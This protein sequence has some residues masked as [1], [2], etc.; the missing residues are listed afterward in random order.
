MKYFKIGVCA[1]AANY[2]L[3]NLHDIYVCRQF[4]YQANCCL[5]FR[6]QQVLQ[7]LD[8]DTVDPNSNY[9]ILEKSLK[10]SHDECF[11]M[12][13]VKFNPKRHKKTPWI[14]DDIIKSINVRNKLYKKLK[15]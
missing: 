14:T 15:Q 8:A 12:C 13:V 1:I 4:N 7:K 11:P 2:F 6:N 9:A 5:S 3:S 10:N